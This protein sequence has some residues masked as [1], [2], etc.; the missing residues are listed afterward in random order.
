MNPTLQ[1]F[2]GFLLGAMIGYGAWR[3]GAL[4]GSGGWAATLTGGLIFGLGGLPW[5]VLLLVFFVSSSILSRTFS[6]RKAALSEK[7]AKGSRRDWIQVLANGSLG[8]LLAVLSARFPGQAWPWLAFTGSM[9]AVNADTWATELGVLSSVPPRLITSGKVVDRGT[10]GGITPLGTLAS[11]GGAALIGLSAATFP[12][13]RVA[14]PT[15][16][17]LVVL[18]AGSAGGLAGSWFDSWLGATY[19]A[20]YYCPHCQK[21][22]ERHPRHTCGTPTQ[23]LRGFRWLGNDLVNFLASLA[24]ALVA[25]GV[26]RLLA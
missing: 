20:I 5:A 9:A 23:R 2:L 12:P 14:W 15:F 22:T 8:A 10:S 11:L 4:S 13:G 16:Y 1:L 3:A 26:W 18:M 17:G 6:H 24:G 19:Q 25:V 7:F 21:E